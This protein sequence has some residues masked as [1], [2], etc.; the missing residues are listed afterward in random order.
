MAFSASL[1]IIA[2]YQFPLIA[3]LYGKSMFVIEES[4]LTLEKA[5]DEL[6]QNEWAVSDWRDKAIEELGSAEAFDSIVPVLALALEQT[7][8]YA[9][10]SC[11]G[12]ALQFAGIAQT[13]QQPE[14]LIATLKQLKI[15]E[16]NL[17]QGSRQVYE[18][19]SWFRVT[20]VI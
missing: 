10:D 1:Q 9:F 17:T 11:C 20:N 15:H 7:D 19:A 3:A 2:N 18:I 8:D 4:R 6:C 14:G 13:T 12:L 5:L 16:K